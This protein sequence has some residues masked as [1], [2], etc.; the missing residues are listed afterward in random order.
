LSKNKAAVEGE[1]GLKSLSLISAI[2]E[3]MEKNMEIE[4]T[5]ATHHSKLGL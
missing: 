1:E 4:L 5:S 3:S 2:Y